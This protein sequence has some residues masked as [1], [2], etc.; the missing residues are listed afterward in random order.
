MWEN[1]GGGVFGDPDGNGDGGGTVGV[2]VVCLGGCVK[3]GVDLDF[4]SFGGIFFFQVRCGFPF[5][6]YV[7]DSV[8]CLLP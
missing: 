2:D 7:V 1:V 8:C 3:R 6:L 4:S 5:P